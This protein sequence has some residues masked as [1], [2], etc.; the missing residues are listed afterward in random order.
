MDYQIWELVSLKFIS[1]VP[2][3]ELMQRKLKIFFRSSTFPAST[4]TLVSHCH[5]PQN[6]GKIDEIVKNSAVSEAEIRWTFQSVIVGYS[7]KCNADFS[8]LF[9]SMFIDSNITEKYHLGPIFKKIMIKS[10]GKSNHF[11]ICFD[12]FL[13]KVP[14]TSKLDFLCHILMCWK[15]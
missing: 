15:L 12:E 4:Y 10:I 1:M 13:N 9:L 7:S 2:P 3:M 11:I 14:Q 8:R 6:Q 5:Q